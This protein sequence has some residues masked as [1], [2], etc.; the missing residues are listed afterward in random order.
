MRLAV[1]FAQREVLIPIGF[2]LRNE[3]VCLD[4]AEAEAID[5]VSTAATRA[6]AARA[7]LLS[8]TTALTRCPRPRRGPASG[9]LAAC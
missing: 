4:V 1:G 6:G 2:T 8:A 9:Q 5:K 3:A 7:A